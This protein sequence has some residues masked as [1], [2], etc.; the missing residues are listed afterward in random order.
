[1]FTARFGDARRSSVSRF[2]GQVPSRR[3]EARLSIGEP[4]RSNP[5]GPVPTPVSPPASCSVRRPDQHPDF[6]PWTCRHTRAGTLSFAPSR[7][8]RSKRFGAGVGQQG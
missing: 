8:R 6:E 1:M 5:P 4:E 2:A 7:F 3:L